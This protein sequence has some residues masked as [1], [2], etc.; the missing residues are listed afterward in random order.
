MAM[1]IR[2]VRKNGFLPL[3]SN[4]LPTVG[5]NKISITAADADKKDNMEAAFSADPS[6][7]TRAAAGAKTVSEAE[8][9]VMKK[10]D[11]TMIREERVLVLLEEDFLLFFWNVLFDPLDVRGLLVTMDPAR[12]LNKAGRTSLLLLGGSNILFERESIEAAC[13]ARAEDK[14]TRRHRFR[15][16]AIFT[17]ED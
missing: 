11:W 10:A 14:P 4:K 17:V 13:T 15:N 3:V 16:N 6:F 7:A 1:A 5:L 2:A 9:V 8:R 12:I